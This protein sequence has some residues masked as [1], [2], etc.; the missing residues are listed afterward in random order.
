MENSE[1]E[2]KKS[3]RGRKP[4]KASSDTIKLSVVPP[5]VNQTLS[6]ESLI[7]QIPIDNDF[8]HENIISDIP[9]ISNPE[10]NIVNDTLTQDELDKLELYK[11]SND[12]SENKIILELIANNKF[13][14]IKKYICNL[15]LIQETK[16]NVYLDFQLMAK[17]KFMFI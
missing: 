6:K 5:Q 2:V 7:L 12:E 3:K 1:I 11:K 15:R 17:S 9:F 13:N 16:E 10:E 8:D 4:K 14:E